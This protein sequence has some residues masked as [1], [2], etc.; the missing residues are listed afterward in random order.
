M[1]LLSSQRVQPQRRAAPIDS[2]CN[3]GFADDSKTREEKK[4]STV[5]LVSVSCCSLNSAITLGIIVCYSKEVQDPTYCLLCTPPSV[6]KKDPQ[7]VLSYLDSTRLK[8]NFFLNEL[9][10]KATI[11]NSKFTQH[12]LIFWPASEVNSSALDFTASCPTAIYLL[13][14]APLIRKSSLRY[15]LL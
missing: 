7:K 3:W 5:L 13:E 15:Y 10:D 4:L 1:G 12:N 9:C 14:I 2:W 8:L 11:A 6:I